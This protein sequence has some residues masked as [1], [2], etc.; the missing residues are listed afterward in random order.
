NGSGAAAQM[1]TPGYYAERGAASIPERGGLSVLT[2]P[3]AV[4]AWVALHER[5]GRLDMARLLA[6]AIAAAH[7]GAPL[8]R[9]VARSI[10]EE[11]DL[12]A[13]DAGAREVYGAVQGRV[14]TRLA[15][16]ALARTLEAI[17]TRG[18]AWFYE[19]E[20]A[21]SID[22]CCRRVASPL[23]AEDF[24]AH[25]GFWTVPLC[26][27]FAGRESLTTAPNSQGLTLLIAQAI[28][29]RYA[30]D[31]ELADLDAAF[32]HATIEA[33]RL[34]YAERDRYVGDP[35]RTKAPVARLL[36][37]E[38]VAKQAAS[39]DPNAVEA[40]RVAVAEKGGT[41]Y[42][43]AVDEDGNAASVI[44]SIYMHFGSTVVVPELGVA[45]HDRGCWFELDEG[46]PRSLAPGRRPFHTLIANLLRRDGEPEV[47]YGSM[48]GDGQPQIGLLLS[49]RMARFGADPQAAIDAPRWRWSALAGSGYGAVAIES[50]A[51]EACVAGLRARGHRV[52]PC[53]DWEESMGH[54]GVIVIDRTSGTL[55]GGA[56]PRGDGAA[57]G[58]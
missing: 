14:G 55:F 31:H 34:A 58:R 30:R 11:H 10:V 46:G 40:R 54:A 51:G 5:F 48:G 33:T 4:D 26:H 15:Q 24:A 45:L 36:S 13:A 16:P 41:T 9:S 27:T 23:R 37:V 1:A 42:F 32:A 44:Q 19:G 2:V 39:I 20:G 35:E 6:P 8:A 28:V 57:L 29:E 47:V 3:G 25:R 18:R 43:A 38:R 50:R 49:I 21:A 12:L 7:D 52:E 17:A 22:A 53:G 56:D